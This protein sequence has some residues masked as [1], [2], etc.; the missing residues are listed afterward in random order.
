MI[1]AVYN[2]TSGL[3]GTYWRAIDYS[4]F[5]KIC[6]R[7]SIA[8][9]LQKHSLNVLIAMARHFELSLCVVSLPITSEF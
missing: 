9:V 1:S 7:E 2:L 8:F 3:C 6:M 5:C 4:S